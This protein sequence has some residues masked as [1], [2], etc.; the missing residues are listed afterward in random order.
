MGKTAKDNDFRSW[1][2]DDGKRRRLAT[3]L[4][5]SPVSEL[6]QGP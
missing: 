6:H 3:T 5:G 1:A 2:G 4:G